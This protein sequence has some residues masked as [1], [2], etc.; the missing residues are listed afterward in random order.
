MSPATAITPIPGGRWDELDIEAVVL[1]EAMRSPKQPLD[2]SERWERTPG[3][4]FVFYR[5]ALAPYSAVADATYPVYIGSAQD[6][7]ERFRRHRRNTAAV[8]SLHGGRDLLLLPAV[9]HSHAAA[10][11]VEALLVQRLEPCWNQTWLSGFGSR[12][13]GATRAGQVPPPWNALH[14]GR[15]VGKGDD[16]ISR[17]L[18][19]RRLVSHLAGTVRPGLFNE[20]V[21]AP[22]M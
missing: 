12:P 19:R 10:R 4:Y 16:L 7:G 8:V 2:S 14:P 22:W 1:D 17:S 11:Y 18:V 5:G 6:L 9:L 20:G 21:G 3:I 15:T 13:Q